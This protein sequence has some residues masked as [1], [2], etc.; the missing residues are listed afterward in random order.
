M[1][2]AAHQSGYGGGVSKRGD[3]LNLQNESTI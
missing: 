3:G 2:D 1:K